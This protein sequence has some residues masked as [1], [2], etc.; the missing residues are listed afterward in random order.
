MKNVTWERAPFIY[1]AAITYM[2][3][4][5]EVVKSPSRRA[6]PRKGP[7][8]DCSDANRIPGR[9]VGIISFATQRGGSTGFLG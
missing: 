7:V 2:R 4:S 3:A 1:R 8:C 9:R 6:F 5:G